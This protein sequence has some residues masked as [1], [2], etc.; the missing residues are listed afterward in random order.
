MR[1]APTRAPGRIAAVTV[2]VLGLSALVPISPAA[3]ANP[4]PTIVPSIQDWTGGTGALTLTAASR[5]IV[6]PTTADMSAIG[7]PALLASNQTLRQT[8]DRLHDDLEL[9]TGLD[10]A[11]VE[12]ATSSAGDV[13]VE[14]AAD[15]AL[16]D[17]GY[18][19]ATTDRI[20]I[21]A[22]ATD[23]VFYAGQTLLQ[24]L[25]LDPGMTDIPQGVI[26]DW[27]SF[28]YRAEHFDV[29]RRYMSV[30]DIQDEIRRAAWNKLNVIQ[31]M[32]NQ[33]NAFRLYSPD[34]AAAAPTDENQRYDEADIA[35]IEAVASEYHVTVV[36]E[37]QNPTKMQPIAGL[38]GVDRSLSSQCGDPSTIDF[39]SASVTAWF[40]ALLDEFIPW[41]DGPYVHL[42][43]DEVPTRLGSCA[44]LTSQLGSGETIDDLQEEYI[45]DLQTTV[46]ANAKHA[47]I[48]V[49]N[50]QI[51]PDTDVLIMNFGSTS[52]SE[53]MRDLGYDVVDSAYKTGP[54]DRF[55]IAP[56]DFEG[57]VVPR[58]DIY[59]WTPVSHPNNAG[60]V[61][62]MWGDDLFFSETDYFI[63]MF[64]GRRAEL[65]ERTWNSAAT[66][67]TF[68]SFTALVETIGLAPGVSPLA[69]VP[70]TS[71]AQPIHAYHFGSAYVPTTATHYPGYW[72][73]S[74]ADSVGTLHGNGWIFT[75][76]YPVAGRDGNGLQFG[77]A[78]SQSLNLGGYR[79][80]GQW[81][82]AVWLKRTANSTNTVLLRDMDHAIKV[83]QSGTS[84]QIGISTYGGSN[85]AFDYAAP[86]NSWVHLT[87]TSD[88]GGTAL[89]ADGE[90][91]DAV[92]ERI[93]LPLGG[94]GG[95]RS[96]GGVIDDLLIYAEALEASDVASLYESYATPG[97]LPDLAE[98]QPATASSVKNGNPERVA[99]K[100]VDGDPTTRW[101][102][103][104]A[105]PQWLRVDLGRLTEIERVRLNWEA[106]YGLAY[107]VQVSDDAV[108]WTTIYSTTSGDGGVDDLTSLA[109][110]GRY[111]QVMG[112]QRGTTYG[113]SLWDLNV[114]GAP[115]D[116]AEGAPATASSVKNANPD[117][118][119]AKAVDG[120]SATRW[121]SEYADPQWIQVDLGQTTEVT[122]V[123]L[124]WEPAYATAYQL[125]V[126]DDA[127]N[128]TTIYSTTGAD[129]GADVLEGLSGNGRYVRMYGTARGTGYGYSLWDFEVFGH[130]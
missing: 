5:I 95:R 17:E 106:A 47:M 29:S 77:P 84:N 11:I 108:N 61:L 92:T 130:R 81:S 13:V 19:L 15:A 2:V 79:V 101:G 39:T 129:G 56:S 6:D 125:Q 37:I 96:F 86:L 33:A 36:P 75:P 103:E 83:E 82:V 26:R 119:A 55:Y 28:E 58:G 110:T 65:A 94:I 67:A 112:T 54:Y 98:G 3:A 118:I 105:D 69:S 88:V 12:S 78:A 22:P 127:A 27:P 64:D 74:L 73:L 63:D 117:R 115:I 51:Q 121:G 4:A 100:A 52:V 53:T 46:E 120:D 20:A 38:G 16:G 90:L 107:E 60:Q 99:S 89:Y 30:E 34:Y 93:P 72:K 48:W 70:E 21:S 8:A 1:G 85:V 109:G 76:T 18:E 25:R 40:Q 91:V 44:Y 45:A 87:L 10:L 14:L 59:A 80:D 116:L 113:Y 104:Y 128:W 35:A 50:T 57:K 68:A 97:D 122:N 31:L 7:T 102:S 43:N 71:D 49:N 126:S 23:G 124:N 111:L 114:Y 24:M 9:V 32:F 66:S 123:R 41:F 42:G 62:A